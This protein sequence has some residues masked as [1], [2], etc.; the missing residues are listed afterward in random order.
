M[1]SRQLSTF[2]GSFSFQRGASV[3]SAMRGHS[4]FRRRSLQGSSARA[5]RLLLADELDDAVVETLGRRVHRLL[6]LRGDQAVGAAEEGLGDAVELLVQPVRSLFADRAHAVLE[7]ERTRLAARVDLASRRSLEML[8][9]PALELGE[10]E[11]DPRA[12]LALRA[13]HLFRDGVLVLPE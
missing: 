13:V 6:Q 2:A 1:W 5:F 3:V 10:R 7:L 8:H 12:G 4:P 9:L 11:L